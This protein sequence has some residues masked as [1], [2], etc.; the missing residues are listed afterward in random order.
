MLVQENIT[1]GQRVEKFCLEYKKG[2]K[3]VMVSEG[4]TIGYKR[5][6]RFPLVQ[7]K[8]VRLVVQESRDVP[9]I[10]EVGLYLASEE[11]N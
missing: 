4:T 5:I 2:E 10:A 1:K 11:E 7:A 8:E 3:W 6:L 9:Q